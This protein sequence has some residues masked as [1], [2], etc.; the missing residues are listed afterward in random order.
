MRDPILAP[1]NSKAPTRIEPDVSKKAVS[2]V[3]LQCQNYSFENQDDTEAVWRPVFY[4]SRKKARAKSNYDIHDKKLLAIVCCVDEWDS[5]LRSL[6]DSY[7]T[8][9]DHKNLEVSIRVRTKP[10]N[11]YQV[12][13]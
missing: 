9:I 7:R 13:W 10:I 5:E 12:I 6:A 4:S 3:L 2:G 1:F 11:E 8:I